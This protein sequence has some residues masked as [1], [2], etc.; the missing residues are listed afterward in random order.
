MNRLLIVAIL[1]AL[2][3]AEGDASL[4]P[5]IPPDQFMLSVKTTADNDDLLVVRLQLASA[6]AMHLKLEGICGT[7]ERI[8]VGSSG[9]PL[10]VSFDVILVAALIET[11]EPG[12]DK[13]F[14]LPLIRGN[15]CSERGYATLE[16]QDGQP[17]RDLVRITVESG[18]YP[19]GEP[20]EIG[21]VADQPL[22]LTIQTLEKSPNGGYLMPLSLMPTPAPQA[23]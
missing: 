7:D 1:A 16:V 19:F 10:L 18:D 14:W 21:R 20:L 23:D 3:F 15:L 22:V 9:K 4:G 5:G 17:P 2:A 12:S 6:S 8:L 13:L 11:A